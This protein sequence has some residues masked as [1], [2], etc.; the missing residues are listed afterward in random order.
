[1]ALWLQ[2]A[3]ATGA[4]G[5]ILFSVVSES[6]DQRGTDVQHKRTTFRSSAF[7]LDPGRVLLTHPNTTHLLM[8]PEPFVITSLHLE[9]VRASD[10]QSVPLTEVYNHHV[11]LYAAGGKVG[12][13]IVCGGAWVDMMDS[14][15]AIGAE[16]RGTKVEFPDNHGFAGAGPWLA[17]IHLIRSEGVPDVKRCIE[18]ACPTGGGSEDCCKHLT[19]CPGFPLGEKDRNASDIKGYSL[20]YTVGWSPSIEQYRLLKYMTLDATGCQLEFHVPARC[21]WMWRNNNEHGGRV[22]GG[23]GLRGS[24]RDLP[25]DFVTAIRP[26]Q[27]GCVEHVSW[28]Y[29]LPANAEGELVYNKGHIHTGGLNISAYLLRPGEQHPRHLCTSTARYGT[30]ENFPV[31]VAGNELGYV[32]GMSTCSFA[33]GQRP[34]LRA[35]DRVRVEAFYRTDLWFNGVMGLMDFALAPFQNDLI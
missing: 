19:I 24:G 23:I 6:S 17:N 16:A 26:P 35:G 8:P 30:A 33:V 10:G 34:L 3:A 4:A 5:R 27:P 18:C 1:M 11:A 22:S 14:I 25:S 21:P 7:Q 29:E 13:D 2:V 9:V 32:V 20:Q 12:A 31:A 15:F 28:D